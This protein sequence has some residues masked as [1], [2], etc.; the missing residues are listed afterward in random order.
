MRNLDKIKKEIKL[1]NTCIL[2]NGNKEH[3]LKLEKKCLQLETELN[4]QKDNFEN[5]E[6][7]N[8]YNE[9]IQSCKSKINRKA[10]EFHIDTMVSELNVQ[11]NIPIK[12]K[13]KT[14]IPKRLLGLAE[15]K[16]LGKTPSVQN[17]EI[18]VK[19]KTTVSKELSLVLTP[20]LIL[21]NKSG[22][23]LE[24][25]NYDSLD[26]M[27]S[28]S[29]ENHVPTPQVY[30]IKHITKNFEYTT[31]CSGYIN[32]FKLATYLKNK[33]HGIPV[34]EKSERYF[35]AVISQM[36]SVNNVDKSLK[37]HLGNI[38]YLD[39]FTIN[40]FNQN[41]NEIGYK[42]VLDNPIFND[43]AENKFQQFITSNPYNTAKYTES[44]TESIKKKTTQIIKVGRITHKNNPSKVYVEQYLLRS[45]TFDENGKTTFSPDKLF[46]S[47]INFDKLRT[48][49]KYASTILK[50]LSNDEIFKQK[51]IGSFDE[52]NYTR[53][54]KSQFN[55]MLNSSKNPNFPTID[56]K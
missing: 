51:Y 50:S 49:P 39:E 31:Y 29:R 3:Y 25:L 54:F 38:G 7:F 40:T 15:E 41:G 32:M 20:N 42:K 55:E 16:I 22:K 53:I 1:L 12:A 47:N 9:T 4:E 30:E 18:V 24:I 8:E 37:D 17:T 36:L 21:T 56:I 48:D 28:S 44:N 13:P 14:S 19:P 33:K 10:V 46:W 34:D 2:K 27:S 6:E 26:A 35:E 52:N 43:N 5:I 23:P 11:N 45:S